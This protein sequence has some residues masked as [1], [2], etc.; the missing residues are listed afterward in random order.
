MGIENAEVVDI[1]RV[2]PKSGDLVLTITDAWD[3]DDTYEHLIALQN[4]LNT[5][6]RFIESGEVYSAY[7][8][9]G[10]AVRIEVVSKYDMPDL[11]R[12]FM[13]QVTLK[14]AELG[15]VTT[16]LTWPQTLA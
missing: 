9:A 7:P 15:I 12:R 5:Y 11:G 4:K 16:S 14:T 6:L 10:R 2:E 3:W 13:E 1:I 8:N